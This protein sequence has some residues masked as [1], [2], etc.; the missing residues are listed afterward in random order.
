MLK[1]SSMRSL[2]FRH[3][4]SPFPLPSSIEREEGGGGERAALDS[5]ISRAASFSPNMTRK[6]AGGA[7]AV[8]G[9]GGGGGG[10][11][12]SRD[13]DTPPWET[14]RSP[15]LTPHGMQLLSPPLNTLSTRL[16]HT[17]R[18]WGGADVVAV[19]HD[20]ERNG[21]G[22]GRQGGGAAGGMRKGSLREAAIA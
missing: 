3:G 19:S 20:G 13:R 14:S 4:L 5:S 17:P 21:N 2:R 12:R 16:D 15:L 9:G 6:F 7:D 10:R 8:G 11:G 22:W 18:A 1:D